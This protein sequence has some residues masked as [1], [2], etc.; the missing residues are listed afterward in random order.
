MYYRAFWIRSQPKK[1]L[2]LKIIQGETLL[3][4]GTLAGFRTVQ[5]QG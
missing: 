2:F 1:H 3:S 5:S 4:E